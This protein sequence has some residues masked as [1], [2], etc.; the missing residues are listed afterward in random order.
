MCNWEPPAHQ[1]QSLPREPRQQL[2]QGARAGPLGR[3]RRG[4][5][6]VSLPS[7]QPSS[8]GLASL[9][10]VGRLIL[11][12][13]WWRTGQEALVKAQNGTG[14][15]CRSWEPWAGLW[16]WAGPP[17]CQEVRSSSAV[18]Q[19]AP[20]PSLSTLYLH[21]GP[22]CFSIRAPCLPGSLLHPKVALSPRVDFLA[23]LVPV[24]PSRPMV[25][26]VPSTPLPPEKIPRDQG[27]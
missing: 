8:G 20:R 12:A 24:S 7:L 21:P 9:W 27:C 11:Q 23:P 10:V 5:T 15:P 3:R 26:S 1:H 6:K 13:G 4:S 25:P 19:E 2:R 17:Y 16:V 14:S 22:G 18:A